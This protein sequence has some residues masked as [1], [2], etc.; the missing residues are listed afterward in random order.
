MNLFLVFTEKNKLFKLMNKYK[1]IAKNKNGLWINP[2]KIQIYN[3]RNKINVSNF[4]KVDYYLYNCI[5]CNEI[6]GKT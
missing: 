5:N 6:N 4:Y 1:K 2:M 3:K